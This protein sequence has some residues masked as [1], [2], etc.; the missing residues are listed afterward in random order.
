MK[1]FFFVL[2]L[3]QAFA[4]SGQVALYKSS[5]APGGGSA[6]AG[7]TGIIFTVGEIFISEA[8]NASVHLSEGFV[9]PDLEHWL[10]IENYGDMAG[11]N[12]FPN[13]VRKYLTIRIITDGDYEVY[14]F[15]MHGKN[16]YSGDFTGTEMRLDVSDFSPGTYLV[17]LIDRKNRQRSVL[18][19]LKE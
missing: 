13:P 11:V 2:I 10:Q 19:W 7:N 8:D 5:L 12:V 3:F 6:A 14:L 18:K 17:V 9:G 16:Y 4:G 15:D 1:K